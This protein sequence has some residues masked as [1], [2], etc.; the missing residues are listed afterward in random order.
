MPDHNCC[1]PGGSWAGACEDAGARSWRAGWHAC[2]DENDEERR[3]RHGDPAGHFGK[4]M[5]RACPAASNRIVKNAARPTTLL[6]YVATGDGGAREAA[7]LNFFSSRGLDDATASDP[8]VEARL[9]VPAA[10]APTVLVAERPAAAAAL[11][12]LRARCDALSNCDAILYRTAR[13]DLP[14][15]RG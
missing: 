15:F 8:K 11:R 6:L 10:V 5:R 7:R 9:M 1:W 14:R 4:G 12:A 3:R 13:A 2:K